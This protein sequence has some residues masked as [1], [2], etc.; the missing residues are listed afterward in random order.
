MNTDVYINFILDK[1]V[2]IMFNNKQYFIIVEYIKNGIRNINNEINED[3]HTSYVKT[4]LKERIG[5]RANVTKYVNCLEPFRFT[6]KDSK[7][8]FEER[9]KQII[10]NSLYD[11]IDN[12]EKL[13]TEEIIESWFSGS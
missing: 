4:F 10:I 6:C 8:S 2:N 9:A 12:K 7:F 3:D 11:Y 13:F 5:L 1:C